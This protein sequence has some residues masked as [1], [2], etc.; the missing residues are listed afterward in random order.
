MQIIFLNLHFLVVIVTVV[1]VETVLS[2]VT[3]VKVLTV[4]TVF[5]NVPV[6]KKR[7]T[8]MKI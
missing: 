6:N 7:K 5:K 8:I 4:M 3:V 1:A 2:V